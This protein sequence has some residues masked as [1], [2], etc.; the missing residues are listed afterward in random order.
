MKRAALATLLLLATAC[1]SFT[2]ASG[3][4][5]RAEMGIDVTPA[6]VTDTPPQ[7]SYSAEVLL[8]RAEGY[9]RERR[10]GEAAE[11]YGRFMELHATHPWASYA[12]FREGMSQ[13]HRIRTADRD[14]TFAQKAKQDFEN[15]IANY[16]DSPAV[17]YARE[18]L[19]WATDQLARHELGIAQ[20][21]LRTHRAPAALGRLNHLLETYPDTPSAR[22]ALFD[23]ARAREATGDTQGALAAY[24]EFLRAPD[25]E[26]RERRAREAMHRLMGG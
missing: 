6:P 16:P 8:S 2:E 9:F 11:T 14:P 13:V 24:E 26:H 15:L 7:V 25:T 5:L 10:F 12:L 3:E 23:L 18:Q 20:F 17:P 1:A 21:Y 4:R 19:A 22:A